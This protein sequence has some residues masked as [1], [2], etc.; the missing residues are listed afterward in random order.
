MGRKPNGTGCGRCGGGLPLALDIIADLVEQL[1]RVLDTEDVDRSLAVEALGGGGRMARTFPARQARRIRYLERK[2]R[3]LRGE[4][5][6]ATRLDMMAI[7][8]NPPKFS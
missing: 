5:A 7:L 6:V 8:E 1:D 3:E 4:T 2:L